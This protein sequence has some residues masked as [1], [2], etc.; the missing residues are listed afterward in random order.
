MNEQLAFWINL[1]TSST[2]IVGLFFVAY[3]LYKA[4]KAEVRQFQFETYKIFSLDLKQDRLREGGLQWDN[5]EELFQQLTSD[6][7]TFHALKNILDFYTLIASAAR[8][9]T[10]DRDKAFEYW[11][12]TI[13]M[14][15]KKYGPFLLEWRTVYGPAAMA[16]LEWFVKEATKVH[17]DYANRMENIQKTGK[18]VRK[19]IKSE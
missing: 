15:W 17:Q 2:A 18:E 13:M 4:R 7:E 19:K 10:I 5:H 11:G 16:D 8:D 9:K 1:L 12:Q 14:F 3:Q 6:L